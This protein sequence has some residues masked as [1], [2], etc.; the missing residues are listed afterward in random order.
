[1]EIGAGGGGCAR[2]EERGAAM[3]EG[4]CVVGKVVE[5]LRTRNISMW[6]FKR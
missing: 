1:M 6:G 5:I 4:S 3:R 2:R